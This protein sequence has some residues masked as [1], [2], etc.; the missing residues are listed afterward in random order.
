MDSTAINSTDFLIT[1]DRD[2]AVEGFH[3]WINPHIEHLPSNLGKKF[4]NLIIMYVSDCSIKEIKKENFKGLIKMR[5]LQ[6]N[7]NQIEKIDDDT[8]G[9]IPAVEEIHLRELPD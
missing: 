5:R 7:D 3:V 1:S 4:P 2:E 9:L 6:L 8:F